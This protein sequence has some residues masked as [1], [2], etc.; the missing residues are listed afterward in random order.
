MPPLSEDDPT[1]TLL[2]PFATGVLEWPDAGSIVFVGARLGAGLA[3]APRE[4]LLCVQDFKPHVDAL[5]R[6]GYTVAASDA[7]EHALVLMLL[8]RQRE[9]ARAALASTVADAR[10]GTLL[11]AS[12]ANH[13]GASSF[14]ADLRRLCGSLHTQAKYHGRVFWTHLDEH[15]IDR[16]LLHE[17]Q[18]LD[19]PRRVCNGRFLSRPG[20]FAWDRVDA[21]SALLAAHLPADLQGAGADLG[22]G[23]GYLSDAVLARCPAVTAWDVYEAD[24]RAL[25][26]ARANVVAANAQRATPA[27]L[28]FHWHDVTTGLHSQVDFVVTNPPFHVDRADRPELGRAFIVA[29][30]NA[31]RPN[32]QLWLVANRHLPYEA[33]L[34]ARFASVR[35][36]ADAQGFKVIA[37]TKGR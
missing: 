37:A 25:D 13:A 16:D 23:Y 6:A 35:C 24:A 4:R 18:V 26:L 33:E 27:P 34:Q 32:G 28:D 30:A 20:V 19:A 8:P 31:L 36:M 14:E 10:P 21:A 12:A 11:V 2:H 15:T 17:W 22:A 3:Q 7:G 1:R 9:Q 5:Q 29:A